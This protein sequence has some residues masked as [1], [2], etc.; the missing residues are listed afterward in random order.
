VP[1]RLL[2]RNRDF[3]LLWTSQALSKL[4][5][6]TSMV[7]I[8]LL[9]LSI[10]SAADAGL[11]AFVE[12]AACVATTLP[13]GTIADRY[14]RRLILAACE[15]G[16]G[17]ALTVLT[18]VIATSSSASLAAILV[19]GAVDGALGG[20]FTSTSA[21]ALPR[22]VSQEQIPDAVAFVQARNSA[23]YLAGPVLGGLLFQLDP[24][25]P[26]VVDA[27]SYFVSAAFVLSIRSPLGGQKAAAPRFWGDL[28]SGLRF[29]WRRTLLRY[30]VGLAAALN[31]AFGGLLLVVV[32]SLQA[33]GAAPVA[34]GVVSGA[35]ALGALLGSF[36]APP[37]ASRLSLRQAMVALLF[38]LAALIPAMALTDSV[39]GVTAIMTASSVLAPVL[40]VLI[41]SAQLAVTPDE[42]QGR[43][44][45]AMGFAAT[46]AAPLG[47]LVGGFLLTR[48]GA[49][50]TFLLAGAFFAVLAAAS[51][52]ARILSESPAPRESD[53]HPL[54]LGDVLSEPQG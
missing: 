13:G 14:S 45:S 18:I 29:V 15:V 9:V 16:S 34:I 19:L 49:P 8:P 40:N 44:Q 42:F 11:V 47:P 31:F 2:T 35:A 52:F 22:I 46:V 25:V 33:R 36:L 4:G 43:V 1:S 41:V 10:G 20:V 32:A 23:V 21:A 24:A 38:A 26:F 27:A 3:R 54:P 50:S 53:T 39:I 12:A 51:G 37:L 5:S 17:L 30:V 7:A 28:V 6:S 48:A